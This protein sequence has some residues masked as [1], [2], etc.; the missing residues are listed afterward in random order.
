M[1]RKAYRRAGH[2]NVGDHEGSWPC[3]TDS[4]PGRDEGPGDLLRLCTLRHLLATK[5]RL[6]TARRSLRAARY[7]T[8]ARSV[9]GPIDD[10]VA[11]YSVRKGA[12]GRRFNSNRAN[13]IRRPVPVLTESGASPDRKGSR[14]RQGNLA[15]R[16]E[17][18]P[19]SAPYDWALCHAGTWIYRNRGY[20]WVAGT[21][22]ITFALSAGSNT[23]VPRRMCLC[24]PKTWQ[25]R[26]RST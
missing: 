12:P 21:K 10:F 7:A 20:V 4:R 6:G 11:L 3:L 25:A 16:T 9:T 17:I 22:D 14:N 19:N 13:R 23:V 2:R 8:I 5:Q 1:D 24:I 18:D 26:S 15:L